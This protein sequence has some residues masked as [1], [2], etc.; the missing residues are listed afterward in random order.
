MIDLLPNLRHEDIA[1][2]DH[3]SLAAGQGAINR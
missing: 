3:Y 2:A 1:Y